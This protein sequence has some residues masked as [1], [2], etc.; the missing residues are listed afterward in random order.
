VDNSFAITTIA[1]ITIVFIEE[2]AAIRVRV[3]GKISI[4][5]FS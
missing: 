4:D 1:F 2:G 5:S 3:K